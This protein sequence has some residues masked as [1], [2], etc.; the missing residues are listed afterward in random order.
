ML[1]QAQ[2]HLLL[3][4]S[5]SSAPFS[6]EAFGALLEEIVGFFL[7]ESQVLRTTNG[8]RSEQDVEDLWGGM[9]ER[10]VQIADEGLAE[11]EDPETFLETKLKI[12]TFIQALEVR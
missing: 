3:S 8:F 4:Q 10:I 2:A 5:T 1:R 12:L 6:L 11:C 7:I 9:C